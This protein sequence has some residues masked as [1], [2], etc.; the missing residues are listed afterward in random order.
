MNPMSSY[1]YGNCIPLCISQEVFPSQQYPLSCVVLLF[2][3]SH[4]VSQQYLSVLSWSAF[5]FSR[6]CFVAVSTVFFFCNCFICSSCLFDLFLLSFL[7]I[8]SSVMVL[9]LQSHFYVFDF[10]SFFSI[11][12]LSTL[13]HE[14]D[15]NYIL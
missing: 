1:C 4:L 13:V 10:S 6:S 8:F 7:I 11:P 3:L 12:F 2:C 5:L 9:L 15:K 14:H